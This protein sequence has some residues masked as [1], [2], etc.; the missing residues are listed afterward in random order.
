MLDYFLPG[1]AHPPKSDNVAKRP[2]VMLE[3]DQDFTITINRQPSEGGAKRPAAALYIMYIETFTG[4]K[5]ESNGTPWPMV[6]QYS[7]V[8]VFFVSFPWYTVSKRQ[9]PW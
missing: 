2:P 6:S 5:V 7:E 8:T 4:I 3:T 1:P 9:T